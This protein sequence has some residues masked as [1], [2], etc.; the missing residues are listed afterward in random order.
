MTGEGKGKT[1]SAFGMA[2]R[3]L[4][5]GERASVIQF[6]KHDGAYG[7]V[8]A[9][10]QLP[11]AEVICSGLG[12][13]PRD[14]SSPQWAR[15]REVA[16]AG[17]ASALQRMEDESVKMVILDEFFYPLRFGAISVEEAVEA[18]RRFIESGEDRVLVMTGRN[19]PEE[20]ISLADTVSC[21]ECM[22]HALQEGSKAQEG[23]EY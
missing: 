3:A 18:V 9:L 11:G 20:L 13:T 19:V 6:V 21:V 2:L 10:R 5:H 4:G 22:K 12:F 16:R 1:T 17:W 15:H 8:V 14:E 7:E 23:F